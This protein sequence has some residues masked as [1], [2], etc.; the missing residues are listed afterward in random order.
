MDID[1]KKEMFAVFQTGADR[2]NATSMA[3]LGLLYEKGF[4][5]A[6]DFD[7][8]REWYEKAAEKGDT[9][10]KARLEQ[11]PARRRR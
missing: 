4:G 11:L 10:A 1:T 8:A 7:K 5:V 9:S 6:Q 2:G 3:N